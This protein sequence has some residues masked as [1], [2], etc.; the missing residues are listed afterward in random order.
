MDVFWG[1]RGDWTIW[2][3]ACFTLLMLCHEAVINILRL[4]VSEL[5]SFSPCHSCLE[6][7][8]LSR[9]RNAAVLPK[10]QWIPVGG[11]TPFYLFF[12]SLRVSK[13]TV[14]PNSGFVSAGVA[15][16]ATVNTKWAAVYLSCYTTISLNDTDMN[17]TVSERG[18]LIIMMDCAYV[19]Y[20]WV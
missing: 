3:S 7:V 17:V 1:L 15:Q 19:F 4:N 12:L 13:F 14:V 5:S 20:L 9:L 8:Q 18:C 6:T 10:W 16:W 11:K 2:W